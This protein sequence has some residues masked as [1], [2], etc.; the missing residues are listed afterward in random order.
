MTGRG[1][2]VCRSHAI[3]GSSHT[4]V[5][6]SVCSSG[7]YSTLACRHRL[8]YD[9]HCC[10]LNRHWIGQS[11]ITTFIVNIIVLQRLTARI[12]LMQNLASSWH[13]GHYGLLSTAGVPT[14]SP[15]T[16][17][18]PPIPHSA[19]YQREQPVP[20]SLYNGFQ[21]PPPPVY[22]NGSNGVTVTNAEGKT[23]ATL[24]QLYS[25]VSGHQ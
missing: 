17:M 9:Y 8:S 1:S 5:N 11:I 13:H 16:Q 19:F 7:V 14:P 10:V 2:H 21:V 24:A 3:G 20:S 12:V 15:S 25:N 6:T 4:V 18:Y 22:C 23:T